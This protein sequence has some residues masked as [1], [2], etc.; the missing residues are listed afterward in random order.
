MLGLSLISGVSTL[1]FYVKK[2]KLEFWG[3]CRPI[4][5][6]QYFKSLS[7]IRLVICAQ[8]STGKHFKTGNNL[9]VRPIIII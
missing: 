4:V 1:H 6:K 9:Y 8:L 5:F 7:I 2:E 3:W